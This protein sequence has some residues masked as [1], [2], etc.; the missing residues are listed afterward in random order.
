MTNVLTTRRQSRP[1]RLRRPR[2]V[3]R[4]AGEMGLVTF[5]GVM[6]LADCPVWWE[7]KSSGQQ[8][9]LFAAEQQQVRNRETTIAKV[10]AEH[11][12]RK[13]RTKEKA[14]AALPVPATPPGGYPSFLGGYDGEPQT[15][16]SFVRVYP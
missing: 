15:R 16:R 5:D 9:E 13:T 6:C 8:L 7:P 12:K 3:R 1:R 10:K 2:R 14:A 4:T 11:R